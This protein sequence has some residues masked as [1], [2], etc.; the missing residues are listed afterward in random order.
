[1]HSRS[2]PYVDQ[3]MPPLLA[4]ERVA[5]TLA[6]LETTTDGGNDNADHPNNTVLL[7]VNPGARA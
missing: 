7:R 1:M 6:V 4:T 2:H 5:E 3:R